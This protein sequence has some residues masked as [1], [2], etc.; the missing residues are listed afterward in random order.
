MT[1]CVRMMHFHPKCILCIYAM[2]MCTVYKSIRIENSNHCGYRQ[3]RSHCRIVEQMEKERAREWKILI[4][5]KNPS[6]N[7][8]GKYLLFENMLG[9]LTA[10]HVHVHDQRQKC[11]TA[12]ATFSPPNRHLTHTQ[13]TN[14]K[15]LHTIPSIIN[16]RRTLYKSAAEVIAKR[17]RP[18]CIGGLFLKRITVYLKVV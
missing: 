18:S 11:K 4:I 7:A 5:D 8:V 15:K 2:L 1:H 6:N 3:H 10:A 9:L 14:C 13:N 16:T 12:T 17:F